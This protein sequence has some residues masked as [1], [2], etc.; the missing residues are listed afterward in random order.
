MNWQSEGLGTQF[1]CVL[2]SVKLLSVQLQITQ[3]CLFN[4]M[5]PPFCLINL[6]QCLV[7]LS[8]RIAVA[9]STSRLALQDSHEDVINPKSP[10]RKG[11]PLL[12]HSVSTQSFF[13]P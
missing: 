7:C 9:T 1:M 10:L 4:Q 5:L 3:A 2:S 8:C 6:V 11:S 12:F 13:K